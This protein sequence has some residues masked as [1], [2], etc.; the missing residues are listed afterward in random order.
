MLGVHPC[1]YETWVQEVVIEDEDEYAYG[2]NLAL[3]SSEYSYDTLGRRFGPFVAGSL[4]IDEPVPRR[5]GVWF[6]GGQAEGVCGVY[7]LLPQTHSQHRH[8]N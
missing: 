2:D 4:P 3:Y 5:Q 1:S 8:C 6:A 7:V